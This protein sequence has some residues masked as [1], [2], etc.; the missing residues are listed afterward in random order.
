MGPFLCAAWAI[1]LGACDPASA[2]TPGA[3]GC[4]ASPDCS[5]KTPDGLEFRGAG[6]GAV[7]PTAAG[8]VQTIAAHLPAGA[9]AADE[10]FERP[11][12]ADAS[13]PFR[14]EAVEPPEVTVA[15][16][17]P[18][19]GELRL[20]DEETGELFDAIALR[21]TAIEHI[22][23]RSVA[24]PRA[25][26]EAQSVRYRAP[27]EALIRAVPL[28]PEELADEGVDLDAGAGLD[29][30]REARYRFRIHVRERGEHEIRAR[31]SAGEEY[32]NTAHTADSADAIEKPGMAEAGARALEVGVTER[33]CFVARYEG[34]PVAGLSWAFETDLSASIGEVENAPRCAEVTAAEPEEGELRAS[35]GGEEKTIDVTAAPAEVP[36]RSE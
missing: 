1:G 24:Y 4:P 29:L 35:A 34:D 15:A 7:R 22:A 23:I 28:G 17:E 27:G 5:D 9:E 2:P 3:E 13:A 20:Y 21:A 11:F 19:R 8:G 26:R 36:P 30:E 18:G 25:D 6:G 33:V 10:P 12:E 16:E 31:S 14:L 32:A